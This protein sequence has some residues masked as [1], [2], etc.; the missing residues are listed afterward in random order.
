MALV[1]ASLFVQ[2]MAPLVGGE[3]LGLSGLSA[4]KYYLY[5]YRDPVDSEVGRM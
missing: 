2:G 4:R 5:S 3:S 1:Q